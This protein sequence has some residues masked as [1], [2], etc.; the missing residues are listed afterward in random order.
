[1]LMPFEK[2]FPEIPSREMTNIWTKKWDT[3]MNQLTILKRVAS[4]QFM[5]IHVSCTQ[6]LNYNIIN[7]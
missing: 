4:K 1:M 6:K 5:L 2:Y 7:K 3:T